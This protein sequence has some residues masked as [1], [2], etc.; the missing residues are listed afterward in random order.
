MEPNEQQLEAM[1]AAD[2][3]KTVLDDPLVQ[4]AL[5]QIER[6]VVESWA[7]LGVENRAQAEE[8]KRLH[9]AAKQFRAIFEVTIAGGTVAHNELLNASTMEIRAEAAKRRLYGY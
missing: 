1:Q 6:T 4:G 7:A 5:A 9:W 8:L 2:R 3:A